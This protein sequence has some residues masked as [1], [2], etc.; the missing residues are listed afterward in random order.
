VE[1]SYIVVNEFMVDAGEFIS[2]ERHQL[3]RG[4]QE[5]RKESNVLN[6]PG[7]DDM[8]NTPN[9]MSSIHLNPQLSGAPSLMPGSQRH[10]DDLS[11]LSSDDN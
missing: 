8:L 11:E 2:R 10:K 6:T 1:R 4:S 5:E 9:Q 3:G 7:H